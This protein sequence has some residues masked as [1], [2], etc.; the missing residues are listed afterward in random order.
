MKIKIK[1]I[2]ITASIVSQFLFPLRVAAQ[3]QK[4]RFERLGI[5][6][7]LSQNA[8]LAIAQD[9]QGFLWIGTEDGLNKYDGYQFTVYKHDPDDPTSLIDNYVSEILVDRNGEIWIGT[10]SGLERYDPSSGSFIHYPTHGEADVYLFGS[11]VIS[12]YEDSQG[13]L[14]VGTEEEGL[15]RLDRSSGTFSNFLDESGNQPLL[16]DNAARVIYEDTTGDMWIGTHDGMYHFDRASGD[17]TQYNQAIS[18]E[19]DEVNDISVIYE[20]RDGNLWVGSEAG[21]I[22]RFDRASGTFTRFVHD[23]DD[24]LS[25][26]HDRVRAIYQDRL[27]NFWVGTQNGLNL[28]PAE[29]FTSSSLA[30]HFLHYY[31]DPF[32]ADS[33]GSS[34]VWSIFEDQSGVM[35][36]G[37][38]GG[39]LSKYNRATDRFKLYQHDP[40]KPDSLSDNM[41]W[42]V[43]EASDESVWVGTFNGGL[44]VLDREKNEIV[45]YRHDERDAESILSDDVRAL[46]EDP[47]GRMWIGTA[48]GLELFDSDADLFTHSI[49]DASDPYSLSGNRVNVLLAS[50][51]GG[52][53]VGTR[54]SGL[55][56]LD[57]A[58]G[59]FIRYRHDE[60][61]PSSLSDDRIWALY[62]D[63]EGALWV[64]TLGGINVLQPGSDHFT[65]YQF[66][67]EDETS[68]SSDSVFA[69]Y[70]DAQDNM[71]VGTWG[72][73]LN[74]FD[75]ETGQFEHFTERDGLPNDTIYGIEADASGGLWMSTNR[76]LS[77]FDPESKTFENYDMRDGL[78]DNEFNVG[79]HFTSGSGEMFFGGIRGF[80]AFFPDE[81]RRNPH[82]PPIVITTFYKFNQ[83][84]RHDLLPNEHIQL[85]Y[86]DNFIAFEFAALDF[87]APANNQYAYMLEGFDED[88]VQSG[89]RRY[90]SYTNLDGGEYIFRVRGSNSDGVWNEE[91]V[92]VNI[93]VTPPY[94]ET[95]WF[96]ILGVFVLAA[97]VFT[98]FRGNVRRIEARSRELEKL[99]A[100]RTQEIERRRSEINALYLADE[101]LIRHLEVDQ[102]F[103]ALVEIAVDILHADKGLL[104]YWDDS[105][106][107]LRVRASRGFE[108]KTLDK[109]NHSVEGSTAEIVMETGIPVVIRNV[110]D[111]TRVNRKLMKLEGI[112]SLMRV[113]IQS[114]DKT[115][116]VLTVAY[117]TLQEF[118]EEQQRLFEALAQRAAIAI[119]QAQL[120]DQAQKTA[121]YEERQ[122]LARDLHDAVTQTLFSASLVSE[123]LP[124]LWEKDPELGRSRLKVLNDLTKGALAEMRTLLFELRPSA[125]ASANLDELMRQLADSLIGRARIPVD[126]EIQGS[127]EISPEAK[128]V[129][130][131]VAQEALNNIAKHAQASYVRMHIERNSSGINLVIEDDGIGF[132]PE[133]VPPDHL[134]LRIMQERAES[135]GAKLCIGPGKKRG[136]RL[137][138]DWKW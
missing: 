136:T 9:T 70:E 95:P 114:E 88:W 10:R 105:A 61:D 109:L 81:I 135:I 58:T 32:D 123:V 68:L 1:T 49:N 124:N 33:L 24:P 89:T 43:I 75:R 72:G 112:Q 45:V 86:R 3:T 48:G 7:G 8:V 20:D 99:V 78:Q 6:E 131:R 57:P 117:T 80:N 39:G 65:R 64:G 2:L 23:P 138:L 60:D 74:R 125:L 53:W 38:W 94:W 22:S 35:W 52:I 116:G 36:F 56:L 15:N 40:N 85:S 102:V 46:L 59:R 113:P 108:T 69:F 87:Y 41:I 11:W 47:S 77:R 25:L 122:R 84:I 42:A 107:R 17:F 27:G 96:Q 31:N 44:S 126:L 37:T 98:G 90:V 34:T 19:D 93:T 134:G 71:W 55:N 82:V 51:S 54:Y 92:S 21:G 119:E 4:I 73:G 76:G 103:Q 97:L 120:Q 127:C 26:S 110:Q 30:L 18:A 118:G 129:F 133:T 128:I 100:E 5:E 101:K 28:V 16:S 14:W 130:Y 67:A 66:D 50:Q 29:E 132:D 91:G 12:L 62:E 104:L 79:A 115:Y 111:D 121:V 13:T 83:A 106:G 63:R 137:S